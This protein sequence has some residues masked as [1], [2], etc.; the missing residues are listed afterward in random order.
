MN[1]HQKKQPGKGTS[2]T[3]DPSRAGFHLPQSESQL[4]IPGQEVFTPA[5]RA[6]ARAA[7]L[8][9][10]RRFPNDEVAPT[11][12]PRAAVGAGFQRRAGAV[13]S[14]GGTLDDP[15]RPR[16]DAF[17]RSNG[18]PVQTKETL[19]ARR[20]G[21]RARS[22]GAGTGR[23]QTP[24][25]R[26]L[27]GSLS[28]AQLAALPA[29]PGSLTQTGLLLLGVPLGGLA[30]RTD[31]LTRSAALAWVAGIRVGCQLCKGTGSYDDDDGEDLIRCPRCDGCGLGRD[32]GLSVAACGRPALAMT[33]DG[34]VGLIALRC[35]DRACP[36]CQRLRAVERAAEL[37][38]A[39]Q[40]CPSCQGSGNTDDGPCQDCGSRGSVPWNWSFATLTIPKAHQTERDCRATLAE[41]LGSWR[42]MT[43][44]R[45]ALG[46]E[47]RA[48]YHGGV[49]SL[50]VVYRES[51]EI[52]KYPGG[53]TH[54]VEYSGWHVHLHVLLDK[55]SDAPSDTDAWLRREWCLL[56]GGA[57]A[58]QCIRDV[59]RGDTGVAVELAKY[60]AKPLSQTMSLTVGRELFRAIHGKRMLEGFGRWRS[61]R[62]L[63][64]RPKPALLIGPALGTLL[65]HLDGDCPPPRDFVGTPDGK[66]L[67]WDAARANP[68]AVFEGHV[69]GERVSLE[70]GGHRAW[71]LLSDGGTHDGIV[72]ELAARE[73]ES[74]KWD[75]Q[76]FLWSKIA[77]WDSSTK[78][79]PPP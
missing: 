61:W 59:E 48:R 62:A 28:R 56:V 53:R 14:F 19:V 15:W 3:A 57:H 22:G 71:R 6:D 45:T 75:R 42:N 12:K 51:G 69:G 67:H 74:P 38:I 73:L 44:S 35:R 17:T 41:V 58:G 10:P 68:V 24:T 40:S 60:V 36:R 63:A 43:S 11:A 4:P 29:R 1:L 5:E 39:M 27:S 79:S 64:W 70:V 50:E 13:E 46:R 49:R 2:V 21:S 30:E 8:F 72:T 20:P 66:L 34:T 9:P 78:S 16:G 77:G 37:C 33:A 65:R 23:P 26:V 54:T 76:P 7:I 18:E 32:R 25:D 55:R 52:V 31:W 47:F